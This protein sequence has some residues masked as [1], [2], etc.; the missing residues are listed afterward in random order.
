LVLK[1]FGSRGVARVAAWQFTSQSEKQQIDLW[2]QI[3]GVTQW[4]KALI[5]FTAISDNTKEK[6]PVMP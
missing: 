3:S 6:H 5:I 2:W 1:I 4:Q